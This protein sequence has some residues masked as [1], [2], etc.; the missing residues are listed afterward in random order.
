MTQNESGRAAKIILVFKT[1][2]DVGF[3][4]L[5][6]EVVRGYSSRLLPEVI[7]AID[8]S[9]NYDPELPYI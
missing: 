5:A 1:H 4:D 3:T 9:K 7:K 8:A 2:F 6:S